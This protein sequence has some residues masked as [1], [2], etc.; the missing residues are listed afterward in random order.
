MGEIFPYLI[1][2]PFSSY[3][4]GRLKVAMRVR[5]GEVIPNGVPT[6]FL[7]AKIKVTEGVLDGKS[8]A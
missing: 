1:V 3:K 5:V 2:V 8:P 4:Y 6:A 7:N